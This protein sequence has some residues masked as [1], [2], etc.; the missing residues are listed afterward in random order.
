MIEK[1]NL[2]RIIIHAYK[3]E[4]NC[5]IKAY[6]NGLLYNMISDSKNINYAIYLFIL[7]LKNKGVI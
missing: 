4:S 2:S 5:F 3:K 1:N 7:N 6:S